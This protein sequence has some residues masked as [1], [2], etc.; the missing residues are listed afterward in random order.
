MEPIPR[1]GVRFCGKGLP[2]LPEEPRRA[3]WQQDRS[4]LEWNR[5]GRENPAAWYSGRDR[6]TALSKAGTAGREGEELNRCSRGREGR[7]RTEHRSAEGQPLDS[8]VPAVEAAPSDGP[9]GARATRRGMAGRR[10]WRQ[11]RPRLRSPPR[12]LA[13]TNISDQR[14]RRRAADREG[15]ASAGAPRWA[16]VA[17]QRWRATA[18][19]GGRGR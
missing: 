14:P 11:R 18:G 13:S 8:G 1:D 15:E 17:R 9:G 19:R 12:A 3:I 5:P 16:R 2:A 10:S 4:T 7:D 6:V